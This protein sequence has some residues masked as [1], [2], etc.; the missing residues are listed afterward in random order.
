MKVYI[1]PEQFHYLTSPANN[2]GSNTHISDG[3]FKLNPFQQQAA[4]YNNTNPD[5]P[6]KDQGETYFY[7]QTFYEPSPLNRVQ[8]TFAP[9]NSWVG[10]AGNSTESSRRSVKTK[11]WI[12]TFK[13]VGRHII[14]SRQ[15]HSK[16]F[17][18]DY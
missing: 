12:N 6:I 16:I 14:D 2:T 18:V 5:N 13:E 9:G 8:E 1:R 15:K 3:L 4:F 10:T 17:A 11:Y 7:G